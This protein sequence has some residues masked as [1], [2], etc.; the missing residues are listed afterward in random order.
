MSDQWQL[1]DTVETNDG[2]IEVSTVELPLAHGPKGEQTH[3]TCL[4]NAPGG[5]RVQNR[6]KTQEAAEKGHKRAI[7][8]L[9]NGEYTV[10]KRAFATTIDTDLKGES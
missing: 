8:A 3:E 4:F 1:T 7:E 5:S 10:E 9:E 2:E 6:Y